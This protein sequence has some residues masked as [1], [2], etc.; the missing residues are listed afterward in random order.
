MW[1]VAICAILSVIVVLVGRMWTRAQAPQKCPQILLDGAPQTTTTT[2]TLASGDM[3]L[4]RKETAEGRVLQF[5]GASFVSHAG[6][7]WISENGDQYVWEI[8][9]MRHRSGCAMLAPLMPFLQY[10]K[11]S[12]SAVYIR[13]LWQQNESDDDRRG[14]A[15]EDMLAV[16]QRLT[17]TRYNLAFFADVAREHFSTLY[18]DIDIDLTGAAAIT[19]KP[20]PPT[21]MSNYCTELVG[22]TYKMLGVFRR[23]TPRWCYTP[24]KLAQPHMPFVDAAFRF[25]PVASLAS[26]HLEHSDYMNKS[27]RIAI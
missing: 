14:V 16:M 20:S 27:H 21:S 1:L 25:G 8:S 6:I 23:E 3:V 9:K 12:G 2:T 4:V 19:P 10:Y 15:S 7:I 11:E 13:Q 17:T 24:A 26:A 5:L 18:T 22:T